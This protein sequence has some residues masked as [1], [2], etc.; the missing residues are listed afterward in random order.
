M[1]KTIVLCLASFLVGAG[2][3]FLI[4]QKL[5]E[6]KY[7]QLAEDEISSVKEAFERRRT[8]ITNAN[9]KMT[10]VDELVSNAK[11]DLGIKNPSA[12]LTRSS[13]DND[14]Y[15]MAKRDYYKISAQKKEKIVEPET[16]PDTDIG[17]E[18]DPEDNDFP[19]ED[20]EDMLD[21]AGM[22]EQDMVDMTR[23][24]RTQPYVISDQQ[25]SEE[26]SHHDKVSLYYYR[27]DDVLCEE[28][29][30]MVDDIES[31][32]GYDALKILDM[33]TTVWVRNE[34]LAIDYEVIALNSS[35]A[36]TVHGLHIKE[37]HAMT[38]RERYIEKQ[39]RREQ[40][41]EGE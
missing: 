11:K 24:D 1:K 14:P 25:Y 39:K 32:I 28:N 36:E 17:E 8:M 20:D 3:G 9:P 18:D 13:L 34:P 16:A 4:T 21:A 41:G 22:T 30:E 23:V 37:Q 6:K 15:E 5:I 19:D 31:V 26:F 12:T 2:A 27:V 40:D 29:E 38:P 10:V 7:A 35:F 33:Q